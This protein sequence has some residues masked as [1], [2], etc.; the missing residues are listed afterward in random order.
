MPLH[1]LRRVLS[2]VSPINEDSNCNGWFRRPREMRT[3]HGKGSSR[4]IGSPL[5]GSF[6]R[7]LERVHPGCPTVDS[8]GTGGLRVV[9]WFGDAE[10]RIAFL[11]LI[12]HSRSLQSPA[13][14]IHM[15]TYM[16]GFHH[17]CSQ[18]RLDSG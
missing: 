5:R 15:N 11:G 1:P 16:L 8:A 9:V 13:H 10:R 2:G 4:H 14:S 12:L 3:A 18:S 7:F 6:F 17:L